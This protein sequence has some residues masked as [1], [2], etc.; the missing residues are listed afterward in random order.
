MSSR[1]TETG[2]A[3][4]NS[5]G[6]SGA[7]TELRGRSAVAF[8]GRI[9]RALSGAGPYFRSD[10]DLS[11]R[12][13]ALAVAV[14]GSAGSGARSPAAV[15]QRAGACLVFRGRY[16]GAGSA[17]RCR[18]G[19][20]HAGPHSQRLGAK[21][22]CR[23]TRGGDRV[24]RSLFRRWTRRRRGTRSPACTHAARAAATAGSACTRTSH[25]IA[26]TFFICWACRQA[27]ERRANRFVL[28]SQTGPL[29]ISKRQR[30]RPASPSP[31]CAA[32]TRGIRIPSRPR[33]RSC[34]SSRSHASAARRLSS[35]RSCSIRHARSTKSVFST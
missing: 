17:R 2:S 35:R 14:A 20:D 26:M 16:G 7:A 22:G 34:R 28:R 33:S 4:G 13:S 32:S 19:G 31:H 25:I 3:P 5:I 12:C 30:R 11:E 6:G 8:G 24:L 15:G 23:H 10:A 9:V 29:R 1:R 27:P 18:S 21:R